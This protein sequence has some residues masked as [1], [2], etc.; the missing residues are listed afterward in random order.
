VLLLGEEL[1]SLAPS[2]EFFGIAQ[3]CGP[4]AVIFNLRPPSSISFYAASRVPS[5]PL[6]VSRQ[7]EDP[8]RAPVL[9]SRAHELAGH[10]PVAAARCRS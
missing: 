10:V 5:F 7:G 6:R 1:A 9:F 3:G 2:D 4:V 8:S